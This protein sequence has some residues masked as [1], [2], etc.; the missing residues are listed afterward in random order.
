MKTRF[1]IPFL[2]A[3]ARC[4]RLPIPSLPP[5]RQEEP[6]SLFWM[7]AARAAMGVAY[8]VVALLFQWLLKP[9]LTGSLLATLAILLLHFSFSRL[10]ESRQILSALRP[11]FPWE[12]EEDLSLANFLPVALPCFLFL[13][14]NG[15]EA[16]WLPAI[17]ALGAALAAEFSTPYKGEKA[18]REL[19]SWILG[20]AVLL[21]FTILPSLGNPAAFRLSFL[22]CGM[23]LLV[24][25]LLVPQLKKLPV[26]PEPYFVNL[27]LGTS[28]VLLLAVL[29]T[30]L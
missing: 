14:L 27:F 23:F 4:T 28:F 18:F 30:A 10:P 13:L 9:A 20:G 29:A 11:L 24:L 21:L 8:F 12:K 1:L 2:N 16:R 3:L 22:R 7:T 17:F 19:S 6:L 5:V 15:H 25:A 26:R